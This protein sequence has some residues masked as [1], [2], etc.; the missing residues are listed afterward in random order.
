MDLSA[1]G[2][3]NKRRKRRRKQKKKK[4]DSSWKEER[5]RKPSQVGK[6]H[7]PQLFSWR[8][9]NRPPFF[10]PLSL[11]YFCCRWV[12]GG[13]WPKS[14]VSPREKEASEAPAQGAIFLGIP[15]DRIASSVSHHAKKKYYFRGRKKNHL[16]GVRRA[17]LRLLLQ[18][19][20]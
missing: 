7:F 2:L 14:R 6:R 15:S 17:T 11:S 5:E 3:L 9:K 12:G 13:R 20:S 18:A 10:F 4:K 1:G 19:E 16:N 8:K